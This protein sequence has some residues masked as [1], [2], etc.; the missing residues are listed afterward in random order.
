[1]RPISLK[2]VNSFIRAYPDSESS[3][4][5]WSKVV[6]NTRW[7]N[8][9]HVKADFPKA[10]IVGQCVV[11]N[12]SGNKYRLVSRIVYSSGEFKGRLY[13]KAILTHKEY[14]SG[15]WKTDCGCV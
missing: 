1:M 2:R 6:K 11:F 5:T 7:S 12:I 10:S 14:D 3:L 9:A 15:S 4:R 8:F 13:I